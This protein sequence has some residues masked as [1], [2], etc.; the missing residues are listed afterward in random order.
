MAL[1]ILFHGLIDMGATSTSTAHR[2]QSTVTLVACN[3]LDDAQIWFHRM[4]L[5][6]GRRS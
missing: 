6:C 3:L 1:V 4:E 2:S 5:N